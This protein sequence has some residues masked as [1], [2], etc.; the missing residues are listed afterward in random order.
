M[1]D[2]LFGSIRIF[3]HRIDSHRH[4]EHNAH[5]ATFRQR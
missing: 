3:G 1:F 4:D 2:Y 5:G